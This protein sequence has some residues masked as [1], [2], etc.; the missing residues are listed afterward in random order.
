M[1]NSWTENLY[2]FLLAFLLS[3]Y[4]W[5]VFWDLRKYTFFK[6]IWYISRIRTGLLSPF[7]NLFLYLCYIGIFQV[8]WKYRRYYAIVELR[9]KE[10]CK[11]ITFVLD[12]FRTNMRIL[13][14]LLYVGISISLL[15]NPFR[16]RKSVAVNWNKGLSWVTKLF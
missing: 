16:H 13:A 4:L 12:N 9:E 8:W 11:C 5:K 3:I 6:Y 7:L 1:D 2:R 10:I 14:S 15:K